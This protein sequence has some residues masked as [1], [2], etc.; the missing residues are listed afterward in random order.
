MSN[1][2]NNIFKP[3]SGSYLSTIQPISDLPIKSEEIKSTNEIVEPTLSVDEIFIDN[4]DISP[5]LALTDDELT[6]FYAVRYM[7]RSHKRLTNDDIDYAANYI[8]SFYSVYAD[9]DEKQLIMILTYLNQRGI[10]KFALT[11][12]EEL[13]TAIKEKD[14]IS[15]KRLVLGPKEVFIELYDNVFLHDDDKEFII[16]L[17]SREIFATSMLLQRLAKRIIDL[18]TIDDKCMNESLTIESTE[19]DKVVHV[20]MIATKCYDEVCIHDAKILD[21]DAARATMSKYET[22]PES[23]YTVDKPS[24]AQNPQIYC[25]DTLD[26]I[27]SITEDVPINPKS[28]EPFSDYT[29]Q[30][31]HQRFRKE[32]AMYKRYKEANSV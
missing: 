2:P 20:S 29:L 14:T 22:P 27:K 5:A 32:I 30:L 8:C 31:I 28:N 21:D 9:I 26:L 24:T 1:I 10:C 23:I 17:L 15:I 25:F 13:D 12:N 11:F 18:D 7:L 4:N 6:C 16:R 19:I 3:S